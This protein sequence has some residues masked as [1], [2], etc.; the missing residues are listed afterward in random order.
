MLLCFQTQDEVKKKKE[1][2]EILAGPRVPNTP[3]GKSILNGCCRLKIGTF[4]YSIP[5]TT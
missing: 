4:S 1:E 2:E 5:F 3:A